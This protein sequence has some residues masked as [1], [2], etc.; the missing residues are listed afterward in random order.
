MITTMLQGGL[1]NQLFQYFM[2]KAQAKRLGTE[3]RVDISLLRNDSM[4]Q[5]NLGLFPN[6]TDLICIGSAAT[7]TEHK[8]PY[9]QY[10]VD[11]IEDGDVL[12]G[13]WQSEKYF[14][15]IPAQQVLDKLMVKN[16]PQL[17]FSGAAERILRAGRAS[18]FLTIRRTDYLQKQEFHG[19]LPASY[20]R[21]ALDEVRR[22][23]DIEPV[24][25]V[26]S[27]DPD[28]CKAN[29]SPEFC[30]YPFEVL[31]TYD[32]TTAKHLGREDLDLY[33]MSLCQNGVMANSSFS[34]WGAWLGD[35]AHPDRVVIAP[36]QWFTTT[37]VDGSGIV[38]ERWTKI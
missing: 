5:Y 30:E 32:Q 17:Y 36:K 34:W 13:Y 29:L 28:W 7:I 4:R 19:V 23:A 18:T 14:E 12:R 2:G 38:P 22:R 16:I 10:L 1:G 35:S 11:A 24:V 31:G 37:T 27:D 15:N 25:F 3:L 6:I 8:M 26:F 33:L 9:D 20:Y 21:R